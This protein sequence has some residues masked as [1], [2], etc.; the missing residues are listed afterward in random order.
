[1]VTRR[2]PN[3]WYLMRI[4]NIHSV[5][6]T[7]TKKIPYGPHNIF[8]YYSRVMGADFARYNIGV[9]LAGISANGHR[10]PVVGRRVCRGRIFEKRPW[11]NNNN[12]FLDAAV[13]IR[14]LKKICTKV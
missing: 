14:E 11:N 6:F 7:V 13:C 10:A 8:Y 2:E 3:R 12:R 5:A 9:A 4:Y 1:M